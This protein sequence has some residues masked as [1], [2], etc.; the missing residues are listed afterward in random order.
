M[1]PTIW[2]PVGLDR[3]DGSRVANANYG[4]VGTATPSGAIS[5]SSPAGPIYL[6]EDPDS[7]EIER[8]EQCTAR[9]TFQCDPASAQV[10]LQSFGRGTVVMDTA[11]NVWK[12]LTCTSQRLRAD[13]C[14]IVMVQEGISFDTPP[15]QFR[16]EAV[17]LNPDLMKHPRY[18]FLTPQ[19]RTW[20]AAAAGAINWSSL[21]Q[22]QAGVQSMPHDAGTFNLN[23][24]GPEQITVASTYPEGSTSKPG[25]AIV[26]TANGDANGT[27]QQHY[28]A[29]YELMQKMF[30][31]EQTFYLPG[32]R[33]Q[34]TQFYWMPTSLDPGGRIQDPILA[35]GLPFFF[36]NLDNPQAANIS[37]TIFTRMSALNPQL[38]SDNGQASGNTRISWLRLADMPMVWERTWFAVT[39]TWLGAPYSHWDSTIYTPFSSPY[40]LPPS[41]PL[42][43]S[44]P[45]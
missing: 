44:A 40:P 31:G 41:D 11:N 39:R 30:V 38:Y 28:L 42:G 29:A 7:P 22:V 27:A 6:E 14:R 12:I 17:E 9:H 2:P 1:D 37:N 45:F 5:M 24:G 33:V 16:I 10:I 18:A 35:G 21:Q 20:S 13:R 15:D 23:P 4:P 3:A 26:Y 19:E 25:S 32:F 34:W 8:G 36:W 43:V